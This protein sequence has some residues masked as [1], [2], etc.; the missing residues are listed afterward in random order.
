MIQPAWLI[1]ANSKVQASKHQQLS[2]ELYWQ[3][4]EMGKKRS[5]WTWRMW[6]GKLVAT[7]FSIETNERMSESK[8]TC[9]LRAQVELGQV[10]P[11]VRSRNS[12]FKCIYAVSQCLSLVAMKSRKM[13]SMIFHFFGPFFDLL[14][15][16]P[17]WF[18]FMLFNDVR[19]F[20]WWWFA[21]PYD[22]WWVVYFTRTTRASAAAARARR[23]Q[24]QP[25]ATKL[26]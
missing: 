17:F 9:T 13:I 20:F 24:L 1:A 3:S 12:W 16:S 14:A 15:F 26:N 6:K 10:V 11:T 23:K 18:E 7:I 19:S 5:I 8:F 2:T 21:S 4:W 22:L 25:S